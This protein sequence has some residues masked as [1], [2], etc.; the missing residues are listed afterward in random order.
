[1]NL[2][3]QKSL[4]CIGIDPV[5]SKLPKHVQNGDD[6]FFNFAKEIIDA[7]HE[8]VCAY[9]PNSAFFEAVGTDG[10]R[11]LRMICDYVNVE[12]PDLL[13]VIDAKRGDIGH[14][15]EAYAQ[16]VFDYL[17][18]DA[19]TLHP[20]LGKE[21][22]QPFL[23]R[24]D[25]WSIILCKTSNPGSGEFQ[26]VQL[27]SES[28][29]VYQYIARQV[30]SEWNQYNNCML[31]VG[32][33]YPKELGE[34]RTIV[35]DMPLLVPGIGTQGGDLEKTL[36][37]GLTHKSSG[38]IL[39]V[40]RSIIYAGSGKDFAQKGREEAFQLHDAIEKIRNE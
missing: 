35:G 37:A 11:Q 5:M 6:P 12:Y 34:I 1:M 36:H 16:Y 27:T 19:V 2:N 3:L 14:S 25:K 32:A 8:Y 30:A 23:D 13:L 31:V 24:K 9:K 4:L 22:L 7:T 39:S 38:L 33:T 20:I 29:P 26:N 18:A 15:S 40:S 10:I 17:G 21:A 28:I